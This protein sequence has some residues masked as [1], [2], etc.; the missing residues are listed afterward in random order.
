MREPNATGKLPSFTDDYLTSREFLGQLRAWLESHSDRLTRL[1]EL[2]RDADG[3]DLNS[4][5]G[6]DR[7]IVIVAL[8]HARLT[9][10]I[11]KLD[12]FVGK[13]N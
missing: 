4:L 6:S 9:V 5:D 13:R 8:K 1:H 2:S 7:E 10:A 3:L 11:A 12:R